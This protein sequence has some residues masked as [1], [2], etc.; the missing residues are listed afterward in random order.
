[1][2]LIGICQM[3]NDIIFLLAVWIPSLVKHLLFVYILD[4]FRGCM[5][6]KYHY[7]VCGLPSYSFLVSFDEQKFLSFKTSNICYSTQQPFGTRGWRTEW[8]E[9]WI[10]EDCGLPY[11]GERSKHLLLLSLYFFSSLFLSWTWAYISPQQTFCTEVH[12]HI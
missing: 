5:Y 7:P 11:I 1:M 8:K 4:S 6:C 3:T 2:L 10:P 12:L 9:A